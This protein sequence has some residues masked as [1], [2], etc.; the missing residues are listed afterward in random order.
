MSEVE[1]IDRLW[2][3]MRPDAQGLLPCVTQDLRTR[4]VLMVAWVSREALAQTLST[5]YAV[6]YSRSRK[7]LWEKGANSGK[8]Q[9]IVQIRLDTDADTL[10][11]LVDAILPAAPDGTD[12]YFNFRQENRVWVWD[13]IH[14]KEPNALKKLLRG[15]AQ[16][17]APTEESLKLPPLLLHTT[18]LSAAL[19]REDGD[20]QAVAESA[21]ALL[22]ALEEQLGPRGFTL[23]QLLAEL[24][25]RDDAVSD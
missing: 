14:L 2:A 23:E 3:N 5:G 17:E 16:D 22:I 11:Y 10:L 8:R 12:T 21:R 9:R 7:T 20:P 4:A 24:T 18:R 1:P 13:P 6:Y 19:Q 15:P 25:E